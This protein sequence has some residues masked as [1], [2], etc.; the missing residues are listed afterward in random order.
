MPKQTPQQI[1][2]PLQLIKDLNTHIQKVIALAQDETTEPEEL[3]THM[4]EI[5]Q[6]IQQLRQAPEAVWQ[7]MRADIMGLSENLDAMQKTLDAEYQK[8]KNSLTTLEQRS[9]AQ[10]AYAS[11]NQ[12]QKDEG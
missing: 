8:A 10:K 7:E 12:P 6:R 5:D 9:Q 3:S 2:P 11:Y 4:D 1:T